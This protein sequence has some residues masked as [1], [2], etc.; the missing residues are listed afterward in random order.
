MT[1][2]ETTGDGRDGR[3]QNNLFFLRGTDAAGREAETGLWRCGAGLVVADRWQTLV[4]VSSFSSRL[5]VNDVRTSFT[6]DSRYPSLLHTSHLFPS[7]ISSSHGRF[8]ARSSGLVRKGFEKFKGFCLFLPLCVTVFASA[9]GAGRR[10]PPHPV[11]TL[12]LPVLC[13]SG[14]STST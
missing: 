13:S 12:H 11:P 3:A 8:C 9:M 6:P 5:L 1:R 7:I 14:M 4:S 2:D 10:R